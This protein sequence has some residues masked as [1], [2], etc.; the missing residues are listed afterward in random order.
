MIS[1]APTLSFSAKT[2]PARIDSTIAG[3]PPSSRTSASGWYDASV[4]LTNRTV[5][6]EGTV[7]TA[8]RS[9]SRFATRTPGVPGPPTNL[10]G[11]RNTASLSAMS[12]GR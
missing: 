2:R 7:G 8:R 6:P 4:G 10:C 11:D 3:V 12:I 1:S 5:P 9:R